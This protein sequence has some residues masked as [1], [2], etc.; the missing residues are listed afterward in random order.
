MERYFQV[1][2]FNQEFQDKIKEFIDEPIE[3]ETPEGGFL[4]NKLV[5][6][7]KEASSYWDFKH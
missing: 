7:V 6:P 4:E 3:M 5:P 2:I 1:S